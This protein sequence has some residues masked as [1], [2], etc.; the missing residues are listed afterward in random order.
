M[1]GGSFNHAYHYAAGFAED[2]RLKLD[3]WDQ[4]DDYGDFP[5]KLE[6]ATRAKLADIAALADF[7]ALLMR[8]AEWLYSGDTSD[9][10][11]MRRVASIEA[12]CIHKLDTYKRNCCK[13]EGKIDDE[14]A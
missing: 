14:R 8:E 1:S 7:T 13:P 2:L 4:P 6:E 9:G 12:E 5:N 10:S 3:T 11:F